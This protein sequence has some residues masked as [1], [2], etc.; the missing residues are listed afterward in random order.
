MSEAAASTRNPILLTEYGDANLD[1]SITLADFTTL[2][3]NFGLA[4]GWANGNFN[5]DALVGLADFTMLAANFG[6]AFA[7][8]VPLPDG[9]IVLRGAPV[10]EPGAALGVIGIAAGVFS[11][12][13]R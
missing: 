3:G 2:A 8:D 6:F 9:S 4:G 11:R 5:G 13:R 10:P 7:G 12:R 1:Q